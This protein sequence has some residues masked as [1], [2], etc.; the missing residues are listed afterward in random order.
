MIR[1]RNYSIHIIFSHRSQIST[2]DNAFYFHVRGD[3]HMYDYLKYGVGQERM[4]IVEDSAPLDRPA[5]MR[6][7]AEVMRAMERIY[8][9]PVGRSVLDGIRKGQKVYIVPYP[10]KKNA[11]ITVKVSEMGG[12][13]HQGQNQPSG[14]EFKFRRHSAPRTCPRP[15]ALPRAA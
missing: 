9:S 2:D 11:A 5:V 15:A 3:R 10:L 13:R 1:F 14:L 7:E 8:S 4:E 6:F 12:G